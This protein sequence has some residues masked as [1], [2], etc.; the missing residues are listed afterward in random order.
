MK[1][2]NPYFRAPKLMKSMKA[3]PL[4]ALL[5]TLLSITG[6]AKAQ[7][8]QAQTPKIGHINFQDL[9]MAMPEAQT[10]QGQLEGFVNELRSTYEQYETE[11]NRKR[12]EYQNNYGSWSEVRRE[13]AEKDIQSLMGR[14]QEFE[15]TSQEK[16]ANKQNELMAPVIEKAQAAV[17]AVGEEQG[18]MY[19]L[20]GNGVLHAGEGSMDVLPLVKVKLNL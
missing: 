12:T 20:D 7:P 14:M 6:C 16:L 1:V 4:V 17:K 5:A 9:L 18:L 10:L 2:K 13:A 15:T 11:L 3:F 8:A 19:I